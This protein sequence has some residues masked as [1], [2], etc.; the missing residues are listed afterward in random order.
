M[1]LKTALLAAAISALTI[2]SGT[3]ADA[4]QA[5][6]IQASLIEDAGGSD[7]INYS[8]KLRMLSQRI[9][10]AG[11]YAHAGIETEKASA[12]LASAT[13]EFDKITA[14]LAHGD[15][16]LNI[17]G[18]EENKKILAGLKAL[19]KRWDPLHEDVQHILDNGGSDDDITHLAGES[20]GVLK[21]AKKL[22]TAISTVYSDPTALLQADALKIDIAGR[23]RMLAQRIS[24]NACLLISGLEEEGTVKEMQAAQEMFDASL[25]AL[26][27]G[28][29]EAGIVPTNNTEILDGLDEVIA[30]W[31][32][33]QP[34]LGAVANGDQIAAADQGKIFHAMNGLTGKMNVL[35]GKYSEQSKL[36][37]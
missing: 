15:A 18:A 2:A 5:N 13:I 37:L 34:I 35:V 9:P 26:R 31:T 4:Q 25:K 20:H 21:I 22:V 28:M 33:M 1:A 24:K 3:T 7:R 10:S 6:V 30:L 36:G 19:D 11:C 16:E 27:H 14:A 17:N 29:P 23:Q 32:E 12:Q 8:G